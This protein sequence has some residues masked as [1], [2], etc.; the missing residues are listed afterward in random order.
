MRKSLLGR[1]AGRL[2]ALLAV[3][4]LFVV[5]RSESISQ[6][7]RYLACMFAGGVDGYGLYLIRSLLDPAACAVIL[8][9]VV[10]SGRIPKL[11]ASSIERFAETRRTLALVCRALFSLAVYV[12]CIMSLARGGFN[13]FIYFQF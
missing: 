10:F 4:L 12:L 7:F 1:I 13:P 8:L 6:A 5:F 2:Y 11:A 9:A 3:T